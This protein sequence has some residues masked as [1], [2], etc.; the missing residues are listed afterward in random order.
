M[1]QLSPSTILWKPLTYVNP[2]KDGLTCSGWAEPILVWRRTSAIPAAPE[3]WGAV[4]RSRFRARSGSFVGWEHDCCQDDSF[5]DRSSLTWQ[6]E[7]IIKQ[8]NP[9]GDQECPPECA[10]QHP[11][12]QPGEANVR[13][14]P[15]SGSLWAAWWHSTVGPRGSSIASS[16]RW[17]QTCNPWPPVRPAHLG[18]DS[19]APQTDER[20]CRGI[21]LQ[22]LSDRTCRPLVSHSHL[23][24][25][26]ELSHYAQR[27]HTDMLGCFGFFFLIF[28]QHTRWG[29]G[30]LQVPSNCFLKIPVHVAH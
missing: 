23:E 15:W 19:S 25:L 11:V 16:P 22:R 14:S 30:D 21:L 8:F 9:R 4:W 3:L 10:H 12:M 17:A 6:D 5:C 13:R 28:S 18:A 27:N 1:S 24:Y 2:K 29:K 26:Q 20:E 7:K